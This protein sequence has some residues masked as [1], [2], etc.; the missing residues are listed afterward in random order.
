MNFRELIDDLDDTVFDV[1]GDVALIEGREVRGMLQV[2]WLQPKFGRIPVALREPQ[3]VIRVADT[4]GVSERQRVVVDL[5]EQ[6]GGG[7][8]IVIRPEPGGDGLV[9]LVLRK[10]T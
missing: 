2:P 3:L 9:T 7:A 1:L 6:D 5:P 10:S 4:Q 8:Y